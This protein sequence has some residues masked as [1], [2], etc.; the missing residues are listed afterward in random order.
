MKFLAKLTDSEFEGIIA[1][2][3]REEKHIMNPIVNPESGKSDF[4]EL[5]WKALVKDRMHPTDPAYGLT[6]AAIAVFIAD[7]WN[8]SMGS[9]KAK[10]W[11]L[12][13]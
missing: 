8:L 10:L 12:M 9:T 5:C 7:L 1:S 3:E 11:K 6:D 2:V 4:F 13:I